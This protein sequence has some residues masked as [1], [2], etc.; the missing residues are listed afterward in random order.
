MTVWNPWHGCRKI[1]PGCAHCYVYR[2]DAEFGRDSRI[3]TKTASFDL[4]LKKNR[5]KEYK[6]QPSQGPVYT[7]MTSDFFIEEADEWRG[8][9]W[10]MMKI[11]SDLQ[12]IITTKRIHR[13]E[14]CIPRDWGDGYENVAVCCTCEDQTR[15]DYR[16][17]IL[18]K[19][20]ICYKSVIH[21]PMLG[22]INIE[23]YLKTGQIRQVICG[24]ESG[25]E[26]RICDFAWVLYSMEQCVRHDVNFHFKQT[27]ANFK[28]GEKIY[29]IHR[30]DQMIQAYKAGVDYVVGLGRPK[31][32]NQ[33][34]GEQ[35]ACDE[36]VLMEGIRQQKP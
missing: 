9:I 20:P 19:A 7:C 15:A 12:F 11:R 30:K 27:G 5:R 21:E 24:G 3:V 18:L 36:N 25:D 1:S 31:D 32:E 4:P 8:E 6:L 14:Q 33:L 28:K 35:Q 2:R 17:P 10:Q 13:F 16:L 29:H 22:R 23:K 34:S 26:A